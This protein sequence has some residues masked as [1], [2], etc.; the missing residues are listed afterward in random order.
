ME[1]DQDFLQKALNMGLPLAVIHETL[2]CTMTGS[3][4]DY[5]AAASELIKTAQDSTDGEEQLDVKPVIKP[6]P[7]SKP[8]SKP[9]SKPGH[10][11]GNKR[12]LEKADA[13]SPGAK[14]AANGKA[15]PAA[16]RKGRPSTP[17]RKSL[18]VGASAIKGLVDS[19]VLA[20]GARGVPW[21]RALA[22]ALLPAFPRTRPCSH[23]RMRSPPRTFRRPTRVRF[24]PIEGHTHHRAWH[25][26]SRRHL[27]RRR[28]PVHA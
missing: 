14:K 2:Q 5:E 13:A 1:I 24:D 12:K 7:V 22:Q 20:P 28:G 3:T 19:G 23:A 16:G 8:I 27:C 25:V 18:G 15:E 11:I 4:Y 17:H 10:L 21:D 9:F 26:D 6:Q